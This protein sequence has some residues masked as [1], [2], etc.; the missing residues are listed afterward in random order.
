M[1]VARDGPGE[2]PWV[3]ILPMATDEEDL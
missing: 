1:P 2:M 3:M